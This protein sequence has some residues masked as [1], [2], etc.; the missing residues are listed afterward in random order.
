MTPISEYTVRRLT[1][2]S[3]RSPAFNRTRCDTS[4]RVVEVCVRRRLG[5]SLCDG[6]RQPV[7]PQKPFESC[8]TILFVGA[9]QTQSTTR[10][11]R[12]RRRSTDRK[13]DG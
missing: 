9:R 6:R 11:R 13:V 8:K 2:D 7:Q 12:S 1:T 10:R 5:Y 3:G 4:R